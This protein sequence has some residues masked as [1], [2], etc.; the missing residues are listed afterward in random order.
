MKRLHISLGVDDLD[1]SVAFYTTLFAAA[2]TELKPGYAKWLL[3][4]PRVNFVLDA[5]CASR[6]VDHLGIQVDSDE[7]LAGITERLAAAA[8]PLLEQKAAACCYAKSDKSW[9]LDPQGVAWEAFHTHDA[10][11]SYGA[12]T[13]ALAAL[14]AQ[15]CCA[16]AGEAAAA[17]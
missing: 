4:D 16:P 17:D 6:G 11:D 5:R 1:R 14:K 3:D 8:A 9:S 2:P 13:G 10:I 7:E 12:D 15:A